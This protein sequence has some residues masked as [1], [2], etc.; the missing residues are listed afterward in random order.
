[1]SLGAKT[2]IDVVEDG[3]EH[4]GCEVWRADS[5]A[6]PDLVLNHPRCGLI[7]IDLAQGDEAM[8]ALNRKVATLRAAVPELARM[9]MQRRLLDPNPLGDA[10]D[11][12]WIDDLPDREVEPAVA[13]S[14]A[15][16]FGPRVTIELPTRTAMRD[17]GAADRA[18]HRVR[19]DA[20]QAEAAQRD[21]DGI[22]AITGPPGSGKTL[23]LCAR[24]NW[25]AELHPDWDIRVLCYNRMLAPYLRKLTRAHP[26]IH[27]STV[28]KFSA[29]L[30]V[31]MSLNDPHQAL[32]DLAKAKREGLGRSV[33]AVLIDE[34][35]DFYPA[36]TA[37]AEAVLK[38]GRGGMVVAGDPKQALY[39]DFGMSNA[40]ST[41][42]QTVT[43]ARPYRS[44]RQILEV[45]S[46]LGNQ[47]E[48]EGRDLAFDGE[49]A[50]LVWATTQ[51]DQAAAVARDVLLLLQDGERLPQDIGVLVTRKWAMGGTAKALAAA[52]VPCRVVYPSQAEDLDLSEP[53]VKILT[54][55]SAK[56]LEFDVVFLVGLEQLPGPDGTPDVDRHGRAGYVGATRARDQL[57]L[58]YTKDN[59]YL[60]RIRALPEDTLRRWVWPD[61][62]PE[63]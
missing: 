18:V 30:G 19:L 7:A 16:Y 48:V 3:F 21:V 46:A 9:Q 20:Q 35:Q 45:T 10:G 39:H 52:G 1:M 40:T 57:V 50:D 13:A 22:L 58:S 42:T 4:A 28:G 38:T 47:L 27:V 29:A 12:R 43:L 25:L 49:P 62:Y 8:V 31:R 51:R 2:P 5:D 17:L 37:L 54:V 26:N 44:T 11:L 32:Q 41:P 33:D 34:W 63:A 60:E 56:G 24:A 6:L 59:A 61:D 55:H 36:W 23:V 15:E 53:S 14:L